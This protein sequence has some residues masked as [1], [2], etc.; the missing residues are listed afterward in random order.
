M[1]A[2]S[3]WI[4]PRVA[5]HVRAL[6]DPVTG[7]AAD[8]AMP[9]GRPGGKPDEEGLVGRIDF[10]TEIDVVSRHTETRSDLGSAFGDWETVREQVA[11]LAGAESGAPSR[12]TAEVAAALRHAEADPAGCATTTIWRWRR[13]TVTTW[14][15]LVALA[16]SI[17]A[18]VVGPDVTYVVKPEHQL[19][20]YLLHGLPVLR[21]RAAQ[22]RRRR[23]H[24]PPR[25]SPIG[26]G[27][28]TS[29]EPPRCVCRAASTRSCRS[30]AT[31]TW[32]GR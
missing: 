15:A 29:P 20:Q 32:C 11:A 6:A 14:E 17:R 18:D 21:L 30:P 8:G 25:R 26:P 23:L 4:D 2:G 12:L 24:P 10:N 19:H 5:G 16:D 31:P 28:P 13:P 3:P 22:G 27:R 9:V 1:L 7:L